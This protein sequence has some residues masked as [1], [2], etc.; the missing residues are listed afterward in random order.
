M[1]FIFILIFCFAIFMLIKTISEPA[2]VGEDVYCQ[3]DLPASY[4]ITCKNDC[5]V[6]KSLVDNKEQI[7]FPDDLKIEY[8][9]EADFDEVELILKNENRHL[10]RLHNLSRGNL[11]GFL[12]NATQKGFVVE[13]SPKFSRK[14]LSEIENLCLCDSD[15]FSDLDFYED[16]FGFEKRLKRANSEKMT[17]LYLDKLKNYAKIKSQSGKVYLTTLSGCNCPDFQTNFEPCKHMIFL[18]QQVGVID[19]QKQEEFLNKNEQ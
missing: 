8:L 7:L 3:G 15:Y 16:D 2:L 1:F 19:K 5:I 4:V 13:E 17:I 18:A 10:I 14:E 6:L 9:K 11:D 12:Y